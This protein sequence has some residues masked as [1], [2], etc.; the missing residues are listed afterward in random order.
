MDSPLIAFAF[1]LM[2]NKLIE[3]KHLKTYFEHKL[4]PNKMEAEAAVFC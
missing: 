4:R 3:T 1:V 2:K